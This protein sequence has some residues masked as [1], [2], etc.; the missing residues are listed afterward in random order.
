M[1]G[2]EIGIVFLT[3]LLASVPG[4][5]LGSIVTNRTNPNTS[6]KISLSVFSIVTFGGAFAL[7]GPDRSYLAYVW[8]VMWGVILGWFYSTENLFFSMVLPK[9]QEAE[10]TGFFVYC[11]QILVWLPPLVFSAMIEAGVKQ[12]WG[13]MS[14]IIFFVI[15]IGFLSLVAPWPEVLEESAKTVDVELVKVEGQDEEAAEEQPGPLSSEA[16]LAIVQA[17]RTQ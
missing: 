17:S 13:L 14:L 12:T 15:A 2:T 10:L 4:S 7:S 6:W 5:K 16:K 8:G 11:T 9:G 1:S 3:T